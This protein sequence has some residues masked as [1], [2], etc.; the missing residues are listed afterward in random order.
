MV[1]PPPSPHVLLLSDVPATIGLLTLALEPEGYKVTSFLA[2]TAYQEQAHAMIGVAAATLDMETIA[3][4]APLPDAIVHELRHPQNQRARH[5]FLTQSRR[6]PVV[7]QIPLILSTT[8]AVPRQTAI[9]AE[10]GELGRVRVIRSPID[11]D[12]LLTIL[13]HLLVGHAP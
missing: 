2:G 9:T 3:T 4:M 7:R 13:R 5:Q 10:P 1:P 8:T 6:D 11:A 12:E